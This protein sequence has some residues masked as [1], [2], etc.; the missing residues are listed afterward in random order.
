MQQVISEVINNVSQSQIALE[1]P[2]ESK[3]RIYKYYYTWHNTAEI[4]L[5]HTCTR[6]HADKESKGCYYRNLQ[7]EA[8]CISEC[9]SLFKCYTLEGNNVQ[10]L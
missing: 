8:Q 4:T 6:M 3:V 2:A 10:K 1:T 9:S 7:V 5:I